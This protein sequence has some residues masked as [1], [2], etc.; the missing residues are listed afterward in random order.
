MISVVFVAQLPLSF[1]LIVLTCL[2]NVDTT[3]RQQT[4]QTDRPLSQHLSHD[5]LMQSFH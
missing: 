5:K 2:G 3:H 4:L 1:D